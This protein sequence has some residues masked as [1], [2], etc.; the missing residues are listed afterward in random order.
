MLIAA[1]CSANP[2]QAGTA[3]KLVNQL[4]VGVHAL[5]GAEAVLFAQRVGGLRAEQLPGLLELLGAA[6]GNSRIFQRVGGLIA[7]AEARRGGG[8]AA[9]RASGA[10]L[11]NLVK[12]LNIV[13]AAGAEAGLVLPT[14]ARAD[15]VFA[16]AHRSLGL[17]EADMAVAF[18][19]LQ[20]RKGAGG[21][22]ASRR[23]PK[24]MQ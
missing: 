20:Q 14:T 7:R 2:R 10:P 12:D 22:G 5:A 4:L 16:H 9:L 23:L 8:E 11:R 18:Y 17:G 24:D 1:Q 6:W 15:A 19:L 13:A 21:K 3:T